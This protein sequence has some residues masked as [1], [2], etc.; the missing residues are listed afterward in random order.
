[1]AL[2]LPSVVSDAGG[3]PEVVGDAA[4]KFRS[5]NVSDCSAAII[6]FL[7]DASRRSEYSE[8]ARNRAQT[9]TIQKMA[10]NYG[11]LYLEALDK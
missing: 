7:K 10:E 5:E 2:G 1:M 3:I 11:K 9:F 8:L 6:E 4:V